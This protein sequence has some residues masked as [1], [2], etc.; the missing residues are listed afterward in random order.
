MEFYYAIYQQGHELIVAVC[1]DDTLEGTFYC[2]ERGIKID[3][4]K[5]FYGK[6]LGQ[7]EDIL[8]YMKDATI[9]NLVG[10]KIVGIALSEGLISRECILEIGDT[11]HAQ[12]VKM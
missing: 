4:K 7:K 6:K 2:A 8:S 9:L 1:D 12:R 10:K 3:V 5:S 11:L